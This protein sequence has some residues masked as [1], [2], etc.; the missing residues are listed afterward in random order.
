M[1][2]VKKLLMLRKLPSIIL[3]KFSELKHSSN[4]RRNYRK[5]L[6]S[7]KTSITGDLPYNLDAVNK[8]FIEAGYPPEDY[9]VDIKGF[10]EYCLRH[11]KTYHDYKAG[12]KKLFIE[13]ALEHYVSLSFCPLTTDSKVI[14]IANAGSPFPEIVHEDYGCNVWSNDLAFP[15]GIHRKKWHAKIGGDACRLPVED[16]LFDLAV[17]HCAFEM[18]EGEADTDLIRRAE[19]FL[20]PG[21][22]LV[23]IPLYMNET[24]HI[25]RDPK[26]Y[27]NPLPAVDDGAELVYRENFYGAAFARFYSV[28]ALI[29]RLIKKTSI[30][31]LKIYSVRNLSEVDPVCYLNWLAV[32]EKK[33]SN[34]SQEKSKGS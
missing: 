12:L 16:N 4:I 15:K 25:L 9:H 3:Q 14:D 29:K 18:F 27:R 13:K 1:R 2:A 8:Q 23:V 34:F 21:G 32:F 5:F 6:E 20:K 33:Q 19:Q 30:L 24:H 11:E 17:L 7:G 28:D 22:K 10:N 31:D 26:T